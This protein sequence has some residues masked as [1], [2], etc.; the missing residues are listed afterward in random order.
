MNLQ[1]HVIH[2]HGELFTNFYRTQDNKLSHFHEIF[3]AFSDLIKELTNFKCFF[4][5]KLDLSDSETRCKIY[6]FNMRECL[7]F[8]PLAGFL[9]DMQGL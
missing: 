6:L 5:L 2:S 8:M 4:K 7:Q 9:L 1:R 3:F